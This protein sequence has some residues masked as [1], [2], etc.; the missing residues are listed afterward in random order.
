MEE[1]GNALWGINRFIVQDK[2]QEEEIN[3]LLNIII[4]LSVES[5]DI[6]NGSRQNALFAIFSLADK[7]FI[8]KDRLD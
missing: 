3:I 7:Q 4:P 8:P 5:G 1:S 6:N 2:L